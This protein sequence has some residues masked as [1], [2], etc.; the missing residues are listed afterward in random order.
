MT[1][2]TAMHLGLAP[3]MGSEQQRQAQLAA[4]ARA[5]AGDEDGDEEEGEQGGDG[6]LQVR[7]GG[8]G[9]GLSQAAAGGSGGS[10]ALQ[11]RHGAE[12]LQM[13]TWQGVD[14]PVA[15]APRCLRCVRLA[16]HNAGAVRQDVTIRA[17]PLCRCRAQGAAGGGGGAQRAGGAVRAGAGAWHGIG[18]A[19][20]TGLREGGPGVLQ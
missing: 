5:F 6:A 9:L 2:G 13:R 1:P 11:A 7:F 4:A 19:L 3:L 20:R 14:A 8:L 18:T 15:G 10:K 17:A 12:F 16:V